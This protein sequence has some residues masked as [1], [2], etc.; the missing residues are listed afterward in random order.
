M[1]FIG[2]INC[3]GPLHQPRAC[4]SPITTRRRFKPTSPEKAEGDWEKRF[5][6]ASISK[7]YLAENYNLTSRIA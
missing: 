3:H 5:L 4:R 1:A 7:A 2:F 6:L